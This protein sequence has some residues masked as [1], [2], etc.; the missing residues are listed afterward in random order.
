VEKIHKQG[1]TIL[2]SIRGGFD[3]DKILDALKEKSINQVDFIG[4]GDT[5]KES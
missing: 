1:E 2:G 5:H 3:K 4:G